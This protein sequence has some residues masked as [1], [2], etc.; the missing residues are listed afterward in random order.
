[1]T[2]RKTQ[3]CAVSGC[4]EFRPCPKTYDDGTPHERKAWEGS[5]RGGSDK[6]W[7]KRRGRVLA[8]D[9]ICMVCHSRPSKVCDHIIA[10]AFGGTDDEWNLQGICSGCDKAKSS[11]EG[12]LGR[13]L[14]QG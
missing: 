14:S 2:R 3:V 4:S 10:R 9:P 8:R 11:A 6:G 12:H 7:K 5:T 1:M 13:K